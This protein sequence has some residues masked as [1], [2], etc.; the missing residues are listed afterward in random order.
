MG[1]RL[2]V[3]PA[4]RTQPVAERRLTATRR[5]SKMLD[6]TARSGPFSFAM[7][8]LP[9][10]I[11][12]HDGTRFAEIAALFTASVH[13]LA[14]THYDFAQ[15]EAWAP[16]PPDLDHWRRRLADTTTLLADEIGSL[17]GFLSYTEDGHIDMLFTAPSAP[18]RG[19]ASALHAEAER[20]LRG[21]GVTALSTEASL[22]AEPFFARQGYAVVERQRV[23]RGG[24]WFARA[25][26]RKN[27]RG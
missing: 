23:E 18:R 11:R 5:A 17:H 21:R 13:E 7:E 4:L 10:Q 20:R 12:V 19:V 27:L 6:T 16:R 3:D 14:A 25:L 26:M 2:A 15:R 1:L 22:V 8:S 9:M 24:Q